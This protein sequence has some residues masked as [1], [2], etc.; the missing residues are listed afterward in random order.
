M[1]DD[2]MIKPRMLPGSSTDINVVS[3]DSD[4]DVFFS[5]DIN[6]IES[7]I[8][9]FTDDPFRFYDSFTGA[10]LPGLVPGA[11]SGKVAAAMAGYYGGRWFQRPYTF[12]LPDGRFR[13]LT[14]SSREDYQKT[15]YRMLGCIQ[16]PG[17]V[18]SGS[19][20]FIGGAIGI[21]ASSIVPPFAPH[22]HNS[23]YL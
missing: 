4:P 9:P 22:T 17:V 12:F 7:L 20:F 1:N 3:E 6:I 19:P 21:D 13:D 18:I 8:E 14:F 11:G 2:V 5:H 10:D 15:K 23:N 16:S